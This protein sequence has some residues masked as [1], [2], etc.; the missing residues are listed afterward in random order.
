MEVFISICGIPHKNNE[1][2]SSAK[3]LTEGVVFAEGESI[4]LDL[5]L[6]QGWLSLEKPQSCD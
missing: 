2:A 1:P 5:V 6:A 3:R 4:H